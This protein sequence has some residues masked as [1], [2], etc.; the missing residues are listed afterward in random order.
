MEEEEN[1]L[2]LTN[3][4]AERLK[5][6]RTRDVRFPRTGTRSPSRFSSERTSRRSTRTLERDI[7]SSFMLRGADTASRSFSSPTSSLPRTRLERPPRRTRRG[8]T[9]ICKLPTLPRR[10]PLSPYRR[11]NFTPH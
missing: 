11:P 9:P 7:S 4:L 8:N 5:C 10:L 3:V 6:S 2:V 1:V